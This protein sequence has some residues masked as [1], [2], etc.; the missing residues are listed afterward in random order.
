MSWPRGLKGALVLMPAVM[1][2]L[3]SS[4]LLVSRQLPVWRAVFQSEQLATQRHDAQQRLYQHYLALKQAALG[5]EL[6]F[7]PTLTMPAQPLDVLAERA[8]AHAVHIRQAEMFD[9]NGTRYLTTTLEGELPAL[10]QLLLESSELGAWYSTDYRLEARQQGRYLLLLTL[11]WDLPATG[12]AAD[13]DALVARAESQQVRIAALVH[14]LASDTQGA[15]APEEIPL[16][17]GGDLAAE[18]VGSLQFRGRWRGVKGDFALVESASGY[19]YRVQVG[20]RIGIEAARV[21]AISPQGV[22]LELGTSD[23]HR[24]QLLLAPAS[25]ERL[26]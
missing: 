24:E 14:Q 9:E 25:R 4:V 8:R 6:V 20:E 26:P 22:R 21:V 1:V 12:S 17:A 19:V 3:A 11:R 23:Q 10:V 18:P 2:V 13:N 15:A 16:K 5:D 7:D